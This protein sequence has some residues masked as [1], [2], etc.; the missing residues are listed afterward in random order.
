MDCDVFIFYWI[1]EPNCAVAWYKPSELIVNSPN[2]DISKWSILSD[3]D[4]RM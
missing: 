4:C 1:S 3:D 2:G